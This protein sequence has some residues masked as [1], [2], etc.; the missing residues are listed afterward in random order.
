MGVVGVDVGEQGAH[1]RRHPRAHVL[2]GEAGKMPGG[3]RREVRA[4]GAAGLGVL[5]EKEVASTRVR[6]GCGSP[7]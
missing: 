7:W 1:H 5:M 4:L 6:G 3:E 2:G